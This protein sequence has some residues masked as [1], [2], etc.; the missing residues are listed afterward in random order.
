MTA[1]LAPVFLSARN[2]AQAPGSS[3]MQVG[4]TVGRPCDY[5]HILATFTTISVPG[6]DTSPPLTVVRFAARRSRLHAQAFREYAALERR[7]GSRADY[8]H[9][10]SETERIWL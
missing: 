7:G 2:G 5:N 8:T 1:Q 6:D 10:P 9:K 3:I 4:D